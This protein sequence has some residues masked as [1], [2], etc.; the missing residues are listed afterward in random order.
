MKDCSLCPFRASGVF[1]TLSDGSREVLKVSPRYYSKGEPIFLQ[2]S[3]TEG[4][5]IL[6][7]GK[8]KVIQQSADG[9]ETIVDIVSPCAVLGEAA[10][11]ED[12]EYALTAEALEAVEVKF[13]DK[14]TM[15]GL[16]SREGGLALEWIRRQALALRQA[17]ARWAGLA[18]QPVRVRLASLLWELY[19]RYGRPL[20]GGWE[21][22]VPLS[23]SEVA[24]MIGSTT[25][26]A[27]RGLTQFERE[28]LLRLKRRMIL[29]RE[30]EKLRDIAERDERPEGRQSPLLRPSLQS[31]LS[32]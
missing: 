24:A 14:K 27:I 8:V 16:L 6:C 11:A 19:S 31:I 29:L 23:R 30:P 2:G 3:P 7:S 4:T 18:H 15:Q 26:T 17:R 32:R 1:S 28:G 22:A 12:G 20:N 25:E 10:L 9:Q 5:F 21:I 13:L